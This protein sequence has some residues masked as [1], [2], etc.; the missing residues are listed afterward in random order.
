MKIPVMKIYKESFRNIRDYKGEW[1]RVATG[2][3]IIWAIGF[4]LL[5]TAFLSGGHHL[6]IQKMLEGGMVEV[7]EIREESAFLLFAHIFYNITYLIAIT[8]LYINGFRYAVLQDRGETLI[9]LNLNMRFIKM[10]LYWFLV[11][12][13]FGLYAVV[14]VG[15]IMGAHLLF[16][17]MGVNVILGILLALYGLY[18]LIRISLFMIPVAIDQSSAIKTSWRITKDNVLRLVGLSLLVGLTVILFTALGAIGV[19]ILGFLFGMVNVGLGWGVGIVLGLLLT[20]FMT[21]LGWA[22]NSK[23]LGLAYIELSNQ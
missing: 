22:A 11:A 10:V 5:L 3:I 15:I 14:S 9:N 8:S 16:A 18:L 20:V 7:T 4:L 21:L 6:E 2:P 1:M 13:L 19:A 12:I 23:A 17:N